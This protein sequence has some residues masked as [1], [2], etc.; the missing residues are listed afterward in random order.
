MATERANSTGERARAPGAARQAMGEAARPT[1]GNHAMGRLLAM[2]GEG[3]PGARHA[4]QAVAGAVA[5]RLPFAQRIYD[6]TGGRVDAR[7]V[8]AAV[9]PGLP[10]RGVALGGRIALRPDAGIEVARHEL[11]HVL[12]GDEHVARRAERDPAALAALVR[13]APRDGWDRD[14]KLRYLRLYIEDLYVDVAYDPERAQE[15]DEVQGALED[16]H[17]KV[18]SILSTA[19]Q[20]SV[21]W[22]QFDANVANWIESG[23]EGMFPLADAFAG[24]D[25]GELVLDKAH[26]GGGSTGQE[27]ELRSVVLEGLELKYDDTLAKTAA[28]APKVEVTPDGVVK[29]VESRWPLLRV[30]ADQVKFKEGP[31]KKDEVKAP[32]KLKGGLTFTSG[33][34]KESL[35]QL[36]SSKDKQKKFKKS[37]APKKK[38][39]QTMTGV[40]EL[41]FGPS[42]TADERAP[43]YRARATSIFQETVRAGW[44]A[45]GLPFGDFARAYNLAIEG[46]AMDDPTLAQYAIVVEKPD[47]LIGCATID[48]AS[49]TPVP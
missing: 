17:K 45:G 38:L 20:K 11:G 15:T 13:G 5:G 12:G 46:A 21:D 7:R 28:V 18:R 27:N 22:K 3:I 47:V 37:V 32:P 26:D 23:Y 25:D 4:R 36:K 43:Y 30:S 44:G 49:Q 6:E 9:V 39:G 10:S 40:V 8:P 19:E 14:P 31:K 29:R 1:P 33:M 2:G 34:F 16:A 48:K 42:L 24:K 41:I 35:G